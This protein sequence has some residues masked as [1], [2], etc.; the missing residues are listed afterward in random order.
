MSDLEKLVAVAQQ[1]GMKEFLEMMR[2]YEKSL[3]G[4]KVNDMA[5]VKDEVV[6]EEKEKE[7]EKSEEVEKV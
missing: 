7:E 4:V 1:I 2:Q 5:V 3:F 6:E